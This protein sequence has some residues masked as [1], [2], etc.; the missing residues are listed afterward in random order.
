MK[1][2]YT[3]LIATL[4]TAAVAGAAAFAGISTYYYKK[5]CKLGTEFVDGT[6]DEYNWNDSDKFNPDDY[7]CITAKNGYV[8]V[9]ALTDTHLEMTGVYSNDRWTKH[10]PVKKGYK[11]I[12]KLI[13]TVNPDLIVLTGDVLTDPFSDI[14]FQNIADFLDTFNTPWTMVFGNHDGEWRASK[15]FFCNVMEKSKNCIFKVGP[16][17][18]QGLGNSLIN[19]KTAD[20]KIFY[21]LILMDSGDGQKIDDSKIWYD[22]M[23]LDKTNRRF[24]TVRIGI[25]ERQTQ[26]YKWA[27]KG[28]KEYCGETVESMLALHFPLKAYEYAARLGSFTVN[29]MPFEIDGEDCYDPPEQFTKFDVM[30]T[31]TLIAGYEDYKENYDFY[32]AIKEL[33]STRHIISGHNH[34]FGYTVNFDGISFTSVAKTTSIYVQRKSDHGKRGGTVFIISENPANGTHITENYT[35]Y[36]KDL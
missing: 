21:S 25:N 18:L 16:T 12:K 32:K 30:D 5:K 3:G 7:P 4:G 15:E 22:N 2:I 35:V 10:Y 8:K 27:V 36:N 31:E 19:F 29:Q 26:W 33:E 1:K 13:E 11:H 20:G 24:G 23:R 14:V 34:C 9:L 28:L 6:V 17:N